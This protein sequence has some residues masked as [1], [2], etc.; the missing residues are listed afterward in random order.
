MI[1]IS[2]FVQKPFRGILIS[3]LLILTVNLYSQSRF[4]YKSIFGDKYT[5]AEQYIHQNHWILDTIVR[6]GIEP[7]LAISI[8]FPELIRYSALQDKVETYGIEVLYVQ[9]GKKYADFSIGRFQ[10]KPSFATKLEKDWS[11]SQLKLKSLF[12]FDTI[13]NSTN[14]AKRVER[15][16][17][18]LWQ[19]RYLSMFI[20]LNEERSSQLV[21]EISRLRFLAAAYNSGYWLKENEILLKGKKNYFHTQLLKPDTCYNYTDISIDFYKKQMPK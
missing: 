21:D 13:D 2:L 19:T 17:D 8:I 6:F 16:K 5:N 15:L 3:C 11:I 20:L 10:I 7:N 4:D 12:Q 9:Y 14:R 18:E 1:V